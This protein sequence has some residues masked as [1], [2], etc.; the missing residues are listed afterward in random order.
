M[1][2]N[3]L[4]L[5]NWVPTAGRIKLKLLNVIDATTFGAVLIEHMDTNRNIHKVAD[6]T[7]FLT[8]DLTQSMRNNKISA[9]HVSVG[10]LYAWFDEEADVYRRCK[11][12]RILSEFKITKTPSEVTVR[13]LDAG[14]EKR[15]QTGNLFKLPETYT[16]LPPQSK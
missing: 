7:E 12:L 8:T 2:S 4:D 10:Q 1:L 9:T 15:V 14:K 3:D 5:L 11:V 13:L 16:S 6:H